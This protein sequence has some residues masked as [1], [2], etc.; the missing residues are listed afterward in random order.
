MVVD[1]GRHRQPR[2]EHEACEEEAE[3]A[4]VLLAVQ[5]GGWR[6]EAAG[7]NRA[8]RAGGVG[9]GAGGACAVP[10]PAQRA[11]AAFPP[12]PMSSQQA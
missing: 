1:A 2:Q 4:G 10:P 7:D 8:S 3:A 12:S 5:Q 9:C 6:G 11:P